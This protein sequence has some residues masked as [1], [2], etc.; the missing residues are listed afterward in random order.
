MTKNSKFRLIY[1]AALT[2]VTVG[3][4]FTAY[5]FGKVYNIHS[6]ADMLLN[7]EISE[8]DTQY[9]SINSQKKMLE[10]QKKDLQSQISDKSSV[11]KEIE[12]S[13]KQIEKLTKDIQEAKNQIETLDSQISDKKNMLLKIETISSSAGG[14][15]LT[16]KEGTY[17]CPG[18]IAPGRYTIKG[19]NTLLV[20]SSSNTLKLSENLDR[21]DNNSFTFNIEKGEKIKIV[22]GSSSDNS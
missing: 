12:T 4:S 3:L 2:A 18:N 9:N 19:T 16:L 7:R 8:I 20:Y 11:N 6:Q 14:K 1:C 15:R 22:S 21:L 17:D 13:V 10:N 5:H